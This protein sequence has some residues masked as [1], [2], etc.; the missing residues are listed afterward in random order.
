MKCDKFKPSKICDACT[1]Y[2]CKILG[3]KTD[4]L[5]MCS[6]VCCANHKVQGDDEICL[7]DKS[8]R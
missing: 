3:G 2:T 5:D 4:P 6:C 8:R 7:A 1:E